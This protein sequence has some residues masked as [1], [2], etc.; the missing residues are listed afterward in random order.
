MAKAK[1]KRRVEIEGLQAKIAP[2]RARIDE[3]KEAEVMEIQRPRLD[4]M[5]GYCLRSTYEPTRY[6]GKI[7]DLV[8]SKGGD[9]WFILEICSI[10]K[11]GNPYL[12]LDSVSPYLNKEWWD[13]EVPMA[14]WERCSDEEYLAFK[15]KVMGELSGQKSLR[16]WIK[17]QDY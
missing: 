1:N 6:Y 8:E 15:A 17:K 10:T 12:H 9:V 3:L 2:L 13:A 5:V 4:G 7:L 11:E 16:R 14:S